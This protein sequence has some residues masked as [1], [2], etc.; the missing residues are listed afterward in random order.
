MDAIGFRIG[1][2]ENRGSVGP[3]DLAYLPRCRAVQSL[4]EFAD[5]EQYY[6]S[7]CGELVKVGEGLCNE[8]A[9]HIP[10]TT[11]KGNPSEWLSA[12]DS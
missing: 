1:K 3:G 10:P 4:P 6:C 11:N 9:T 8:R 12:P 5:V 2:L 7:Q